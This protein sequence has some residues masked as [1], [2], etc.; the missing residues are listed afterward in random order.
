MT[1]ISPEPIAPPAPTGLRATSSAKEDAF[2]RLCCSSE[3]RSLAATLEAE[4]FSLNERRVLPG[5]QLS[6]PGTDETGIYYNLAGT[7]LMEI[8][9][10][11]RTHLAP[12]VLVVTPPR[13]TV[14]VEVTT[15]ESLQPETAVEGM[16]RSVG[17]SPKTAQDFSIR[18]EE[19]EL[20]LISGY[21][22]GS[23]ASALE[24]FSTM[25]APIIEQFSP[26]DQLQHTLR[27]AIRELVV[28]QAGSEAM[29]GALMKQV[30]ITLARR[31]LSSADL[32]VT[33][34][35][36]FGDLQVGRA[37]VQM[38]SRPE[39]NHSVVTLSQTAA[40][41]RSAFVARFV[42]AVGCPPM[43]ALRQLR[44]RRAAT[45]LA[46]GHLSIERIARA[47]GY[48]N[49]SSFFRAFRQMYG[50]HPLDYRVAAQ[51]SHDQ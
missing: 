29:A 2:A 38:V 26:G 23:C 48:A 1:F 3:L 15:N 49:R 31:S 20:S 8:G 11:H 19:V 14:R 34:F 17:G 42:E 21:F 35:P 10:R 27:A 46:T 18:A 32:W 13:Q 30:L 12:H 37:L 24:I 50:Q 39:A 25:S 44:L 22:R 40:L 33:R 43:T 47:V 45:M 9:N 36:M 16:G 41:S 7:G 4:I 51:L 5:R 28:R 6:F